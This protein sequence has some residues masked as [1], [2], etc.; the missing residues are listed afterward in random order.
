MSRSLRLGCLLN[1]EYPVAELVRL[2]Q[3]AESLGYAHLWY[4]DIRLFRE[5]FVGLTALAMS[6]RRIALGPGVADPYSRHPAVTASTIATF[7][8][9]AGGRALLGLGV[10]GTGFRELGI[11][12]KLPVAALR[13]TV[14]VVR[15]L[16]TGE[17]V[18]VEGKVVTLHEGR[19]QFTPIRRSVPIYFATHGA[20]VMKLA[21]EVADGVLVANTLVPSVLEFY[22]GQ[23]AEGRA[24]TGRTLDDL[25]VCLR[26]EMCLDTDEDAARL[27]M[28]RRVAARLIAGYPHWEFL[29]RLDLRLPDTFTA[30][31]ATKD[32]GRLDEAAAS[33]PDAAIDRTVLAG[34]PERVAD[35]LAGVLRPEIRS[36]TIR[37]H[38]LPGKDVGQVLRTFVEQVVPRLGVT[39]G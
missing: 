29:E 37:P 12:T 16:L 26:P 15:R 32:T 7:D 38:A 4:T 17:R 23:L 24:K 20:Q 28:R 18:T 35:Q 19:L 8:E 21:G 11:S 13:E 27:V 5:C 34:C 22:L 25:D 14:D 30:I 33:L 1:A 31:A 10:G 36:I 3:L 9:L 39:V 6:T 2:G